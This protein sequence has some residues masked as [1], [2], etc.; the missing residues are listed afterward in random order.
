MSTKALRAGT[1][2]LL[3]LAL[4][5]PSA[6]GDWKTVPDDDWCRENRHDAAYCEVRELE[7]PADGREIVVDAGPNGGVEVQGW[8]KDRILIQ[9][10]ITVRD[11]RGRVDERDAEEIAG[12]VEIETGREIRAAGPRSRDGGG[13]SVSYR[14]KVPRKSDLSLETT[15]GGLAVR[16]VVGAIDLETTNGGIALEGVGGDVSGR[17]TNGGV[18]VVLNGKTWDG[19]GLDVE[20]WNGGIHVELP[21]DYSARLVAGTRNGGIRSDVRVRSEDRDG[22]V[23]RATLGDGGPLLRMMTRNGGVRI[24]ES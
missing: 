4:A 8:D 14:L 9:A 11:D 18:S 10:R 2:G 22:S 23:V 15:N 21:H 3:A 7:L 5:G 17:T 19:D 6:A 1:A 12:D 16:D 13:W 24:E 20:S